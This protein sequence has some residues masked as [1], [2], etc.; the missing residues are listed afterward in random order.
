[1]QKFEGVEGNKEW[2]ALLETYLEEARK[3]MACFGGIFSVEGNRFAT[4]SR[5]DIRAFHIGFFALDHLQNNMRSFAT[6]A[7]KPL[8]DETA[9]ANKLLYDVS[10]E[11][12]CHDFIPWLVTAKMQM[13]RDGVPGPLLISLA[14]RSDVHERRTQ[15]GMPGRDAFVNN[16]FL[17]AI[18]MFGAEVN[19]MVEGRSLSVY[20]PVKI[21]EW[22]REGEEVPRMEVPPW[23]ME[24][25]A[26]FLKGSVPVTITLRET[27]AYP[28]RNS[29]L[30]EW[31]AFAGWRR[32]AIRRLGGR[33]IKASKKASSIH[34][35]CRSSAWFMP[36][37]PSRT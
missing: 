25:V 19:P 23:A 2:I 29:N 26:G 3:G 13:R 24:K 21:C 27:T 30:D 35:A 15:L 32:N 22:A 11:P 8:A 12:I 6:H 1:M 28:H 14:K 20:T 16:V 17:P 37:I 10:L 36:M 18:D 31:M 33:D 5:G 9:P 7:A 4:A 34:G